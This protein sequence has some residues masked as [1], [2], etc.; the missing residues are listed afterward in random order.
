M[1]RISYKN[2]ILS[3]ARWHVKPADIKQI[4]ERPKSDELV[5]WRE[6]LCIPRLVVLPDGDNE[7]L[8]DTES[9]TSIRVLYSVVKKRPSCTLREFP[10]NMESSLLKRGANAFT[11]EFLFTFHKVQPS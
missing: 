9:L 4:V 1:P 5:K 6:R 3:L 2:I 10:F 8:V 7:L 11:N